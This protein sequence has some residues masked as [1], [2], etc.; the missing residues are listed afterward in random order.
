LLFRESS[1]VLLVAREDWV[2]MASRVFGLEIE[3]IPEDIG[4]LELRSRS[5]YVEASWKALAS[6]VEVLR[7]IRTIRV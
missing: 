5:F 3:S 7:W 6:S 1:R 2:Q 4:S